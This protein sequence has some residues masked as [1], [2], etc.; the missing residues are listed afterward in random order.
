MVDF[1]LQP[2]EGMSKLNDMCNLT[3]IDHHKTSIEESR[4]PFGVTRNCFMAKGGQVLESDYA[5][6]ELVWMYI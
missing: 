6:C 4:Q 5:A 3:W 1:C 2:F